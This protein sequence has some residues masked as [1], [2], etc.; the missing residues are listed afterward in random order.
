MQCMSEFQLLFIQFCYKPKTD[1]K[2]SMLVK[3]TKLI[4]HHFAITYKL[5][6]A[7]ENL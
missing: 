6:N 4:Y 5:M 7:G 3:T 2:N 1:L